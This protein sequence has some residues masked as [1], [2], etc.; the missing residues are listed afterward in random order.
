MAS[1]VRHTVSIFGPV[2]SL[3][4]TIEGG[5]E[6]EADEIHLHPGGQGLWIARMLRHLGERPLLCAPIGG[7]TGRVIRGLVNQWGIEMSPV[8]TTSSSPATVHDR[9][10]GDRDLIAEATAP[11][12]ARHE[13]DDAYGKFLD[14]AMSSRV[15]VVTGQNSEIVPV[16]AYRRLG[17]DL[18]SADVRVVG[19]LHGREL[20]AFLDGGP[21]DV[22]KV[23]D[24]D[25]AEDGLLDG[26]DE[27]GALSALRDLVSRG[28]K[29][30]VL[31][32]AQE[33]AVGFIAGT[34]Y[35]ATAPNLEPA[36]FR[37]AGDS[38][39]AGLAAAFSR[40]LGPEDSLKLACGAGAA[41]VTRHG[42]GSASSDLIPKLA[43]RVQVE[44]LSP[45]PS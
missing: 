26:R 30:V 36:D 23:S 43:E 11:T 15:C 10:S 40:G 39:T 9:R 44:A 19:D 20:D 6:D 8:E 29:N 42:L 28:A 2:L 22:L 34:T 18:A 14:H 38:M 13:L 45:L 27:E 3:T 33:P 32:R 1:H 24:E 21:L 17:H 5:R 4:V 41:N 25:L 31:S 7:E 35:R 12:L 16:E 37:G